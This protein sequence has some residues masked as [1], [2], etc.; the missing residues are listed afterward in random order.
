[1]SNDSS[2][3]KVKR[4]GLSRATLGAILSFVGIGIALAPLGMAYATNQA[5]YSWL[6]IGTLPVGAVVMIIGLVHMIIGVSQTLKIKTPLAETSLDERTRVLKDK[7]ISLVLLVPILA[8]TLP[9]ISFV[10]GSMIVSA[11]AGM[12]TVF[13]MAV[14]ILVGIAL[15]IYFAIQSKLKVL[16]IVIIALSIIFL[17]VLFFETQAMYLHFVDQLSIGSGS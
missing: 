3:R 10:F 12:F 1:M 16:Q 8:L 17:V 14:A 4:T 6:M 9:L 11:Y 13:A 15:S 7:S 2:L 5:A